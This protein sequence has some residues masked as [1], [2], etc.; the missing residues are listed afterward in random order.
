MFGLYW[1]LLK[2]EKLFVF[3]R[4]FLLFGIIFS[5]LIPFVSI[6]V[7][8]YNTEVPKSIIP[9]LSNNIPEISPAMNYTPGN[10]FQQ[11]SA[12]H[13][14]GIDISQI[15][16]YAYFLGVILLLCRFSMNIFY[17][18]NQKKTSEKSRYS[19]KNLA[20]ISHQINPFCFLKTIF[21]NKQDF[22]NNKIA[23]ELLT[24]E[25]EHI[26]QL[27]SLD[28]ILVEIVQIIYW[29]NPI[30]ILYNKAIRVNHEYLAD[31]GVIQES[32]D[33]RNYAN[34]LIDFISCKRN[35]TLT[36][37]FN[38]SLTQKRL[39]ML[40]KS[41][42]T[43]VKIG[44][45][46]FTTL[47]LSA[48]FLL[49]IGFKN[50]NSQPSEIVSINTASK[51]K[52]QVSDVAKGFVV[53]KFGKYLNG[54]S[55]IVKNKSI[56]VLTDEMGRF[57]IPGLTIYDSLVISYE[58]YKTQSIMPIF[59]SEMFVILT[60]DSAITGPLKAR[61]DTSQAQLANTL[62]VID[63]VV[64]DGTAMTE[65]D[66]NTISSVKVL[67]DK[68]ATDKY[69][70]KGKNGVVEF[71]LKGKTLQSPDNKLVV[72]TTQVPSI[73]IIY[74]VDSLGSQNN[75]RILIG[76]VI[77]RVHESESKYSLVKSQSAKYDQ[78]KKIITALKGT[79]ESYIPG[80]PKPFDSFSFEELN[81]DAIYHKGTIKNIDGAIRVF[82]RTAE[83]K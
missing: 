9:V 68:N 15:L 43:K 10:L 65:I 40:T 72:S 64:I 28:V 75:L 17:L 32:P 7:N 36:S 47:I 29:F 22:E 6:P 42:P 34:K 20:L 16:T 73:P 30:L 77:I 5:L 70:E 24:H 38:P 19:G 58:G 35:I 59:S 27:H 74:H 82:D 54:V 11:Y 62:I 18:L 51:T 8:L 79:W 39:T 81:Y 26:K 61:S 23:K 4:F 71:I 49:L 3:N 63:G 56:G 50:S 37:G 14:S 53:N 1:F 13:P 66:P 52:I 2:H 33:V 55:L 45:R 80:N 12:V 83:K 57:T 46:I 76:N 21:I 44:L 25:L 48:V 31:N 78:D 60:N 67:K 41:Q 69:G